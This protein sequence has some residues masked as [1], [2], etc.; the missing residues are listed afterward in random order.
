MLKH[1]LGTGG[2]S[3]GTWS[4]RSPGTIWFVFVV[5]E[6]MVK[7]VAVPSVLCCAVLACTS[8]AEPANV[9][10]A[11]DWAYAFLHNIA[12]PLQLA[13]GITLQVQDFIV[14]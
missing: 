3:T 4:L 10:T 2:I 11:E 8:G 7:L 14:D 9:N 12:N 13:C 1:Y 6:N 5:A